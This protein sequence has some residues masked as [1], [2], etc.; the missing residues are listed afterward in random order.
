MAHSDQTDEQLRARF[1]LETGPQKTPAP[2]PL[3]SNDILG[4]GPVGRRPGCRPPG[5][6]LGSAYV[7]ADQP[8]KPF[9]SPS[10]AELLE[11][12]VTY[13]VLEALAQAKSEIVG[14]SPYFVPGERGMAFIKKLRDKGVKLTIMT[15]SLASTD[16]PIV[17]TGYSRYREAML[18]LGVDL[19]E[20]SST[21]VKRN[22][23]DKL[24][25]SSLGRLHA[26]VFVMDRQRVFIGSLNLDP[27]SASI[28]TEF[29]AVIDSPEIARELNRIIDIDRL[30]SAYRVRLKPNGSGLQW[31]S[32]DD[33]KELM[34]DV[35]PD[36]SFWTRFKSWVIS[37]FVPEQEL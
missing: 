3:P 10:G 15:N 2:A 12:S 34:L 37:A 16:E 33:D 4:Y 31:L 21:R 7:F 5:P 35:E 9:E 29:G 36:T 22:K 19:Y 11:T 8:D 6:A 14:S 24:F 18:K 1:E 20:I 13:N 26:K 23:R 30:Q 25:G 27:R 17:H 28:N 32:M